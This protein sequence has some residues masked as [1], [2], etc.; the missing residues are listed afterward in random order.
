MFFFKKKRIN[1]FI[2]QDEYICKYTFEKNSDLN[3]MVEIYI[4][5]LDEFEYFV[6]HMFKVL[7]KDVIAY[8]GIRVGFF[9][10]LKEMN[11]VIP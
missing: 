7:G 4:E 11:V 9:D 6:E 1:K 2:N 3:G 5:H 8:V 10:D